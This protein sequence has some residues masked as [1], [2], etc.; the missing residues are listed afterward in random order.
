MKALALIL[1]VWA[2][3]SGPLW[4]WRRTPYILK[5]ERMVL[6]FPGLDGFADLGGGGGAETRASPV[7]DLLPTKDN[8]GASL[9]FCSLDNGR[10]TRGGCS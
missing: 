5:N 8:F 4:R 1:T 10:A 9:R 2:T 3:N 6:V 7:E